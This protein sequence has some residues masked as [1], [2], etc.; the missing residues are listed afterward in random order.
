MFGLM[1]CGYLAAWRRLF[2]GEAVRGISGFVFYFAIP[3]LLFRG[4]SGGTALGPRELA[5]VYAYFA[6]SLLLFGAS[7]LAGRWL[8]RL[9]L[10]ELAVLAFTTTFSNTVLLGIPL[11]YAAFGERGVLPVTLITSFHS[12]ILLTLATMIIELGAGHSR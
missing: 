6:G 9:S 4:I 8:F 1:L 7:M 2:S 12:I 10:Q 3:C 11:V 5:I